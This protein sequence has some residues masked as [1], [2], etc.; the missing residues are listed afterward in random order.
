MNAP[1]QERSS[2]YL[3]S[4]ALGVLIIGL[5]T[6]I[7]VLIPSCGSDSVSAAQYNDNLI[8]ELE[9]ANARM[10]CMPSGSLAA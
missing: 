5:A 3:T 10:V 4:T 7:S 1:K 6:L 8:K 2:H 9:Q